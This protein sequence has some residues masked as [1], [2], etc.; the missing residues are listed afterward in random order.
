MLH[1]YNL[2]YLTFLRT[3]SQIFL[4]DIFICA[5]L[6]S[7]QYLRSYLHNLSPCLLKVL[8]C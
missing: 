7:E 1:A 8:R 3:L 2:S 4:F 5:E 6:F